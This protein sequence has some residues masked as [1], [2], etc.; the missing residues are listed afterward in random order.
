MLPPRDHAV[1][2]V[3]LTVTVQLAPAATAA[4]VQLLICEKS[5]VAMTLVTVKGAVPVLTRVIGFPLLVEPTN[6]PWKLRPTGDNVAIGATPV[7]LIAADC[8]L[9]L[10][11]SVIFTVDE[12]L[13][14][15]VGVKVTLIVQL[16]FAARD[17]GQ[18]FVCEKSTVLDVAILM[19]VMDSEL[20]PVFVRT[21][22][23]AE[24]DTETC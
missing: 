16:A 23:S 18:L 14:V 4:D 3:K 22:G 10:A 1:V 17:E 24:L 5:P 7:P 15:L 6:T 21:M 8:G 13:P 19:V 20:E 2:G 12:R 9:P 11:L